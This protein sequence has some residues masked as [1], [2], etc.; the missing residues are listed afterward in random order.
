MLSIKKESLIFKKIDLSLI[1]KDRFF[2]LIHLAIL[3]VTIILLIYIS[4]KGFDFTDEGLYALLTNPFQEI[5]FSPIN[6]DL[7]FKSL[8]RY[9]GY[10]FNIS[11]LRILRILSVALGASI[12]Y[13]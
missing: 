4:N 8:H 5:S 13:F 11:S 3:F 1:S 10:I 12:F 9:T 7:L 6:Y 2:S